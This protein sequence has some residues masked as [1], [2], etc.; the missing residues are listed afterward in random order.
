MQ[1]RQSPSSQ[2][3]VSRPG[4]GVCALGA[5]TV[6]LLLLA[7]RVGS[8]TA[9]PSVY[10]VGNTYTIEGKT[11]AYL[12]WQPGQ[13]STTFGKSFAVYRKDGHAGAAGPYARLS[14]QR[15]QT[16]PGAIHALLK[17]GEQFDADRGRVA[18]RINRLY[19]ESTYQPGALI[20]PAPAAPNP[21]IAQQL[22]VLLEIAAGDDKVLQRVF[23][24]GRAHPGVMICLGHAF[25]AQVMP[26]SVHTYEVREIDGGGSDVRVVGRVT[27]DAANPAVLPAPDRPIAVPHPAPDP[28]SQLLHSGKDH[29]ACRF[30]WGTPDNLRRLIPHMFGY[31][32]YR[33]KESVATGLGWD[34]A[35]PPV[36]DLETLVT[37]SA[38][39]GPYPDAR[40]VNVL[41]VIPDTVLNA[42]QAGD[43]TDRETIF[44]HDDNQPPDFRFQ[45]GDAFY[46]Y[47]AARDIAGHPGAASLG[48]R[49]VYCDRVPPPV[50]FIESID[51]VFTPGTGAEMAQQKGYQHF[52]VRIRQLPDQPAED[53]AARYWVY[54]WTYSQES[55]FE[56]G[57]PMTNRVAVVDHVP[58]QKYLDFEDTGTGAPKITPS[59]ESEAGIT[60]WYTVRAEDDL[61]PACVPFN[62]SGHSPPQW[63]VLR[64]RKDPGPATGT[65]RRCR[66]VPQ[67]LA[68]G[69][70]Q[71]PLSAHGLDESFTGFIVHVTCED[72]VV[73]S[74]DVE[75]D[76]SAT[77]LS[78]DFKTTRYGGGANHP[79]VLVPLPTGAGTSIRVRCRT[80]AGLVSA[81][82]VTTAAGPPRQ[83]RN[84]DVFEFR[85]T[86][87]GEY[88]ETTLVPADETPPIHEFEAPGGI[89]IGPNGTISLT[90][91]TREW[92]IYRR[93]GA[94]GPYEMIAQG[95]G[96]NLPAMES[97]A[98]TAPPT[99][100]GI[101][102]CYYGQLLDE[103]GNAG[104]LTPFDDGCLL[105]VGSLPVPLLADP[106]VLAAAG[107]QAFVKLR[108]FCDPVGVDRF[109]VWCAAKGAADPG[110]TGAKLSP[111]FSPSSP[112]VLPTSDGD[113][114]F[115]PYQTPRPAGGNF[116]SGANFDLV[117]AVPSDQEIHY[118]VRAVGSGEF[119][120]RSAGPFSNIVSKFWK[121]PAPPAQDV[122][123]WPDRELVTVHDIELDIADYT[124]GEGPFYAQPLPA[125]AGASAGI[126]VGAFV[127][128]SQTGP[129]TASLWSTDSKPLES[130]FKFR[131]QNT[132]GPLGSAELES[133]IPFAVY[134]HQV[135]NALFPD[136][137]PNLVQ[138]TPLID[139]VTY[140]DQGTHY[141]VNDPFL[142]T[143]R[144]TFNP[145]NVRIPMAGIFK[146]DA[147]FLTAVFADPVPLPA[148]LAPGCFGLI[149]VRDPLPVITGAAYQYLLVHFD[150][151]GEVE[152]IIPTNKVQQ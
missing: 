28:A 63:G 118:V 12:L 32:L 6:A 128:A 49:V 3:Q 131:K 27:L 71:D 30:R 105:F 99:V 65:V 50:P 84:V 138:V 83:A 139:R 14:V 25:A 54:R 76:D 2:P 39:M 18:E 44:T 103:N 13:A 108:W 15:V 115:T 91:D 121:E 134:R 24:L 112:V 133:I 106:E 97:W 124:K 1:P 80:R 101:K 55:L 37:A 126:L 5:A 140:K 11:Y 47:V 21:E 88:T 73:S 151:L 114:T 93:V 40:R 29:L 146:R 57:N 107:G 100:N 132:G 147:A 17:L 137:V 60:W 75:A 16:S 150:K 61:D 79:D 33:V 62:L 36:G 135:P 8:Q 74:Y 41:P 42:M 109:E 77:A 34:M 20:A 98:D 4:P 94:E 102:V 86:A 78:P 148:Y 52:R 53:A 26:G 68:N 58:N 120:M 152:R 59:D 127:P 104:P 81:W 113:L 96:D 119:D 48:T 92:R 56:G 129:L 85:C 72:P 143:P 7:P 145:H 130:F 123:P 110:V 117:L 35:A 31:N 122:I 82:A 89:Y 142:L 23:L 141:E 22:A 136:A 144:W 69:V 95:A 45:S 111:P 90:A 64:D 10:T 70:R 87:A 149:V 38:G 9:D 116:G 51:N 46:Y 67:C 19:S 43:L 125:A 66:A